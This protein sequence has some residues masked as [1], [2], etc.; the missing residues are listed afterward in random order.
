MIDCR[1]EGCILLEKVVEGVD[2]RLHCACLDRL[3]GLPHL[4]SIATLHSLYQRSLA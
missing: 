2:V 1:A 4:V 3:P